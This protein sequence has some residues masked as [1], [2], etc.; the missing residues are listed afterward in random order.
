MKM[1]PR[2]AALSLS[3]VMTALFSISSLADGTVLES[4]ADGARAGISDDGIIPISETAAEITDNAP[5]DL[6]CKSAVLI[7]LATGTVLYAKNAAES[8]PPA[9]VTKIMT[10]LLTMEA[11]DAGQ[12]ALGDNVQISEYAS[13]MGGSQVFLKAGETMSVEDLLKST[14][15]ASANDAAVALAELVAGSVDGFVV[16]MNERAAQLGMTSTHFENPTG[17]DDAVTNHVTSAYDI[18][19]MSRELSKHEKIFS[20]SSIWMDSIRDGAFGLTNTNRLVRFY[21][22]ATGLKTGS[23]STAGFCISATAKRN[24]LHLCAVIMGSPNRDTR[25]EAAKRLLD[26]GFANYFIYHANGASTDE[27]PLRGGAAATIP[28]SYGEFTALLPSASQG[29]VETSVELPES[30]AAPICAGDTLGRVVYSVDGKNVGEVPI[31][32]QCDAPRISFGQLLVRILSAFFLK[33]C[34]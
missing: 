17:L 19:L 24:D 26:W 34:N 5:F 10:L 30:V 25:N 12:F 20:Y 4:A 1:I 31:V 7:D 13:S 18:A 21:Q 22:G 28:A 6:D 15:I 32:A 9:S 14:V 27:I 3:L 33:Q 29:K 8:L 23:T 2:I 11:M 16:R